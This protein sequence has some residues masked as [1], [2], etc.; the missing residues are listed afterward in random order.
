MSCLDIHMECVIPDKNRKAFYRLTAMQGLLNYT[1]IR[2]WGRIGTKG[3]PGQSDRFTDQ[4][5][6]A[7]EL[8]RIV[9]KRL[10]HGYVIVS[11]DL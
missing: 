11:V 5:D 8:R 4:V 10:S 1:L 9:R 7:Q 2:R 3:Q 6:M